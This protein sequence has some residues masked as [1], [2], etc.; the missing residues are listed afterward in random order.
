[1]PK[2]AERSNRLR[3]R[4][5]G[6]AQTGLDAS[7]APL[8]GETPLPEREPLART[9]CYSLAFSVVACRAAS[10][11]HSNFIER[12]S[13]GHPPEWPF[14]LHEWVALPLLGS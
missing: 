9:S 12:P 4:E 10:I 3:S 1:M 13:P 6:R 7:P 11:D 8:N 14:L 5:T 2:F